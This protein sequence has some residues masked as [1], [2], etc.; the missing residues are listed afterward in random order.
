M[1][2]GNIAQ[3]PLK[4]TAAKRFDIPASGVMDFCKSDYLTAKTAELKP[5]CLFHGAPRMQRRPLGEHLLLLKFMSP[6]LFLAAYL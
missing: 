6:H 5:L 2:S 3:R 1:S 4:V